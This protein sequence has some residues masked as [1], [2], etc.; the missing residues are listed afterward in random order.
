MLALAAAVETASE[1]PLAQAIVNG[2]RERELD[3]RATDFESTTGEGAEAD[4][5]GA[6]V[7]PSATPGLIEAPECDVDDLRGEAEALRDDGQTV[8]FVAVDGRAAGLIARGRPGQGIHRRRHRAAAR[9]GA[10]GRH[11]D[12]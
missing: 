3:A 7:S 4:V 6:A 1:H 8:V 12:R 5:D 9:G 10:A 11:A 2:A